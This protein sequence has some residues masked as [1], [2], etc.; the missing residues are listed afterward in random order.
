MH[1]DLDYFYAQCEEHRD[2]S[3]RGKPVV[4]C[5]YSGRTEKGGVVS[6]CNYEARKFRVSAGLPIAR[7]KKLLEAADAVFLP[8]NRPLYEQVSDRIMD[9]LKAHG[10][11]F[12][13]VGIDEAYLDVSVTSNRNYAQAEAMASRLKQEIVKQEDMTCSIGVAPNKL[14][15]KIASDHKKPDGLTV[16]KPDSVDAFLSA[17]PVSRIPGIGKKVDEKLAQLQVKTVRELLALNPNILIETFG[18]SLGNY[19][20]RAARGQ[21]DEPVKEKEQPVQFSRICTLK[22]DTRETEEILPL[23]N[24]LATS[25][26]GKLTENRMKCKSVGVIAILD[27]LSIHSKSKTLESPTNDASAIREF[28]KHLLEEFLQSMPTAIVRRVGVKVSGLTKM[29]GQTDISR[30]LSG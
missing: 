16:V 28:S 15:A 11:S 13:N 7:A 20:Y 12:E 4:V 27:D 18:K 2:P 5:V 9:L 25:V 29:G 10:D 21:D 3:I 14:V 23:L 17:L 1:I 30:Y 6:T 22:K 24:E 8:M 19:L 26:T